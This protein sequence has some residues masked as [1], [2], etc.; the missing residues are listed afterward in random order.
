MDDA[1]TYKRPDGTTFEVRDPYYPAGCD[2]CGWS[3]SSEDC[4]TDSW[5]DDSDVYC[6]KCYAGGADSGRAASASVL[7]IKADSPHEQI[8]VAR[9][10]AALSIEDLGD[11]VDF[12]NKVQAWSLRGTRRTPRFGSFA[13]AAAALNVTVEQIALAVEAHYWM[14]ANDPSAPIGERQIEHEGE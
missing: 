9:Q 8:E 10:V 4:G 2:K 11:L 7:V 1:G 12:A 13:Q 14:F 5:G 3:G 6:P